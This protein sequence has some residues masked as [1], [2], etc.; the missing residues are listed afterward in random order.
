MLGLLAV[1]LPLLA[2]AAPRR[3]PA[4]ER[5]STEPAT[6][7]LRRGTAAQRGRKPKSAL[8]AYLRCLQLEPGC[9][10]C[11]TGRGLAHW[12]RGEWGQAAS[13][14]EQALA[15]Q[16]KNRVVKGWLKRARPMLLRE[17]AAASRS[18]VRIPL[19][20]HSKPGRA[21]VRLELVG[22][23]QSY[24]ARTRSPGDV[25]EP[26]MYSPKSVRF[27]EDG[28]RAYVNSLEAFATLVYDTASLSKV[29]TIA[30]SFGPE[31]AALFQGQSTVFGYPFTAR[32]PNGEPNHFSGKPVE[33]ALSHGGRFLW[34]PYYRRDFDPRATS[35]SAVAVVDT[36]THRV[37]RVLPTGPIP[38][39]VT[40]SPD[41]RYVAIT[42]WG[43][44]TLGL[45]D[46]SSGDPAKFAYAGE[47][48]V[49]ERAL[50][51]KGL[52]GNRDSACGMCL[53][54]TV[55]SPD[56]SVLLVG[57]MGDGGI[58]GF[59]VASGR[60]LGTVTG[61]PPKPRHL[62][63]SQDGRWL[64][65]SSTTTGTVSRIGLDTLL[66]RLKSAQGERVPVS[67]YESV[68]VGRDVRTID[69]SADGRWLFAAVKSLAQVVVVDT[70]AMQVVSRIRTDGY[71]VGLAVSPDGRQVWTTSQGKGRRGGKSVNVFA[72]EYAQPVAGGP[73]LGTP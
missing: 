53:R 11:L 28:S 71:T 42:H 60:Y 37:V 32:S 8:A 13:F 20:T 70:E 55:F 35:P 59:E 39:Y 50:P 62:V 31:Q 6:E 23:F 27:S 30:H 56:G 54:G 7:A 44:N 38:K 19:G 48:L 14:W 72:V 2:V 36:A 51:M 22:R 61:E 64:Y 43:D 21:A 17:A 49:V 68:R 40:V 12:R 58:A 65:V 41:D 73:Q 33:S 67:G 45:I 24:A 9:V 5:C 69:L 18:T 52:K 47:R 63:L 15:A 29:A 25:F 3:R 26:D 10:P 1:L 34:V 57:R 16:P 46:T 66:A 4:A